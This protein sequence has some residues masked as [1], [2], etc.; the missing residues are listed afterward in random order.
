L[1]QTTL[2]KSLV[3][4]SS[5]NSKVTRASRMLS[6]KAQ[7]REKA[8]LNL[9]QL[10]KIIIVLPEISSADFLLYFLN[11]NLILTQHKQRT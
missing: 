5:E 1:V 2:D 11:T 9:V 7:A 4:G 10:S 3:K 6:K 8:L